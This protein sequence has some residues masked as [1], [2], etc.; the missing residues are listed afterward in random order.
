MIV[1]NARD[2]A[3]EQAMPAAVARYAN[4][5]AALE[6]AYEPCAAYAGDGG[7]YVDASTADVAGTACSGRAGRYGAVWTQDPYRASV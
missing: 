4:R 5:P 7:P 6:H 2:A 1:T 3:H